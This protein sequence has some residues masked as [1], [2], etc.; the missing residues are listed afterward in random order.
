V[1]ANEALA[2]ENRNL[3]DQHNGLAASLERERQH[4]KRL[5]AEMTAAAA[6]LATLAAE[7]EAHKAAAQEA[8]E[9][10]NVSGTGREVG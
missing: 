5:D 2:E 1:R 10:G 7:R 6:T 4:V 8:T 3:G 9:R